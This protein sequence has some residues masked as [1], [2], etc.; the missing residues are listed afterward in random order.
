VRGR[1][2]VDTR[3]A[4]QNP[5]RSVRDLGPSRARVFILVQSRGKY[6]S[7]IL[8]AMN[9]AVS[10]L[11]AYEDGDSAAEEHAHAVA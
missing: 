11:Y 3:E 1:L 6:R 5:F 8:A 10:R 7:L 9:Q 2:S 4:V